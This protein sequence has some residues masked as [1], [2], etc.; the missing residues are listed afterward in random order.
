MFLNELRYRA[1]VA[2]LVERRA[3]IQEATSSYPKR[4]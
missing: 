2:Q 3:A 4:M 1:Q